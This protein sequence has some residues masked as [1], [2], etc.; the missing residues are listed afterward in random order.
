MKR[1][2]KYVLVACAAALGAWPLDANATAITP[3]LGSQAYVA[4]YDSNTDS[5]VG[6]SACSSFSSSPGTTTGCSGSTATPSTGATLN[7]L[8]TATADYGV[9]KAGGSSS[10][11]GASGTPNMTN[12]SSAYGQ[13]Y[14]ADS[15]TITG[16]TGTGT[17]K[18]QFALDG[19]YDF[20][21]VGSG[22]TAGFGL[23]N[24]DDHSYSSGTPTFTS[25]GPGTI[26]NTVVLSTTFTF[27][28]AVDFLVSLT[29]GSNLYD[30]GNDISSYLDLS[31]TALMT[32]IIVQDANGNVIP[33]N[34][35]T[36][37]GAPLFSQ[38]APGTPV[39]PVPEPS[40]LALFGAGLAALLGLALGRSRRR[41]I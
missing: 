25:G 14:F 18:L 17:L 9:L 7:Y 36:G 41:A 22:L 13:A 39:T 35:S 27:G 2:A 26:A 38:L 8:S 28:T 32:A 10:I 24:L 6:G 3:Y 33:F 11:S 37:S 19:S 31:N 15:W 23:V 30:L 5:Q 34:L 40:S 21:Q 12:Y 1:K 20:H 4:F 29:A 16:G